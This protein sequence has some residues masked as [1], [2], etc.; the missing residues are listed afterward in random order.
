MQLHY[1]CQHVWQA[2]VIRAG[3][4]GGEEQLSEGSAFQGRKNRRRKTPPP[5]EITKPG[6]CE[7]VS[8]VLS[9]KPWSPVYHLPPNGRYGVLSAL[10]FFL[11]NVQCCVFLC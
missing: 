2:A 7:F 11:S 8:L 1:C 6:L 9:R 4:G 5:C 3:G 10:Q